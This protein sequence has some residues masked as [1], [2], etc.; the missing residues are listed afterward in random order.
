MAASMNEIYVLK[1]GLKYMKPPIWRRIEIL[2]TSSFFDLH[3]AIQDLF[4]WSDEHLH[5]FEMGKPKRD[6][7]A[8]WMSGGD[9]ELDEYIG[10][11]ISSNVDLYTTL[12]ERETRICDQFAMDDYKKKCVYTYDFGSEWVSVAAILYFAVR[13]LYVVRE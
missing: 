10:I 3:V 11:P 5:Q 2:G 9:I 6:M 1:I 13:V 7:M 8:L 12:P 4:Q